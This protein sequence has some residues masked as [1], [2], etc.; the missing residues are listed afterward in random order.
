AGAGA[1]ALAVRRAG[2]RR[3]VLAHAAGIDVVHGDE[4]A[5]AGRRAQRAAAAAARARRVAADAVDAVGGQALAARRAGLAV[6][7]GSAEALDAGVARLAV[8]VA[9]AGLVAGAVDAAEGAAVLDALRAA[10]AAAV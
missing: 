8:V 1:V 10:R 6:G 7:L 5:L 4:R 3:H 9:E 2:R